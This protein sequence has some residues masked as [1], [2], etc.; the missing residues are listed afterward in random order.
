M[1]SAVVVD[2]IGG[3]VLEM[4]NFIVIK[5]GQGM[6]HYNYDERWH[7]HFVGSQSGNTVEGKA[8]IRDTQGLAQEGAEGAGAADHRGGGG[9]GS[10]QGFQY[11]EV[12]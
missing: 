10:A 9:V 3:V 7:C 12:G 2:A 4:D 6:D 1:G 11:W 5:V 8:G